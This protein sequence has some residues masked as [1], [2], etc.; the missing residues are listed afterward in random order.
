MKIYTLKRNHIWVVQ[1]K[2]GGRWTSL[3]DSKG[4]ITINTREHARSVCR[5]YRNYTNG[6]FRVAKLVVKA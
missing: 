4:I 6:K 1:K 3:A 5:E 2:E